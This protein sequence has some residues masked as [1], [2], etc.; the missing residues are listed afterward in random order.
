[1]ISRL[2][3]LEWAWHFVGVRVGVALLWA[4]EWAWHSADV[5]VR[6]GVAHLVGV[7][8]GVAWWALEWAWH[9]YEPQF[10]AVWLG[11]TVLGGLYALGIFA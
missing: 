8:V 6:V 2:W 5:G 4:L 11:V 9:W 10:W 7:R 1:V 3:A